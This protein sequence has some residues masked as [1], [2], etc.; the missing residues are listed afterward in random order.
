MPRDNFLKLINALFFWEEWN[1]G[2]R[3]E[4]VYDAYLQ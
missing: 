4:Q 3:M 2:E 1:K